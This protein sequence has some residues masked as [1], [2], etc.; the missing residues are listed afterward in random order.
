MNNIAV[1][2]LLSLAQHTAQDCEICIL[3]GFDRTLLMLLKRLRHQIILQLALEPHAIAQRASSVFEYQYS[4]VDR[5]RL[6]RAGNRDCLIS[7]KNATFGG[8]SS[9]SN[10][11][12]AQWI[13]RCHRR[14]RMQSE[15]KLGRM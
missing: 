7:T 5:K 13:D 11:D 9:C 10:L 15:N 8:L 3:T 14:V 1:H 2:L 6:Q 12:T 4:S